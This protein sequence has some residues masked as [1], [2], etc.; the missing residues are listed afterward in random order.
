MGVSASGWVSKGV[1][2]RI[3]HA[4]ENTELWVNQG[5][6]VFQ[7]LFARGIEG[8]QANVEVIQDPIESRGRESPLTALAIC[9]SKVPAKLRRKPLVPR[10]ST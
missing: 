2:K 7:D 4:I 3:S 1:S 10:L 8:V 6:E 5:L 9:F